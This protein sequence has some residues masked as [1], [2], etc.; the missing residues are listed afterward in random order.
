MF[1]MHRIKTSIVRN[2]GRSGLFLLASFLLLCFLSLYVYSLWNSEQ[3]LAGMGTQMPVTATITNANGSREFGLSI[4]T[5]AV[6]GFL[7]MGVTDPVLTAE[8]YGNINKAQLGAGSGIIS[9][10]L[11]GTNTMDAFTFLKDAVTAG[12]PL[13]F[14][15]GD[16][17]K[18]ILNAE[19]NNRNGL[20]IALGD[21]I[22]VN[23]YRGNYDAYGSLL[24]FIPVAP[25]QLSVAGFYSGE[26]SDGLP[27]EAPDIICPVLWLRQQY[28][29]A[30]A[31]FKYNSATGTVADPLSL[32]AFKEQ[33]EALR[34]KQVDPQAGFSVIG[35][36][37]LVSD[38]VFIET[39][40]QIQRNIRTLRLFLG[41]CV[42][43]V[44][45]LITLVSFFLSRSR[46]NE[47]MI[48]KGLG[49]RRASLC[50]DL[51]AENCSLALVSGIAAGIVMLAA[52]RISGSAY[53]PILLLF[54]LCTLLGSLVSAVMA[55]RV[56]AMALLARAD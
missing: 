19:Y 6:D 50:F 48:A 3:L 20:S 52:T 16:A 28:Q 36:A 35:N 27:G 9:I 45:A 14:L 51:V 21:G 13:D 15:A 37:L 7:R 25:A 54:M 22:A 38:K 24:E 29:T 2:A 31:V 33:A 56:S 34:F 17:P 23:L 42:F 5:Q 43:L 44:L 26:V 53:L 41:P 47:I 39:A 30:N 40:S 11:M 4:P 18:C 1:T 12:E 46:R 8:S 55:T 10:H 49:M 32:N